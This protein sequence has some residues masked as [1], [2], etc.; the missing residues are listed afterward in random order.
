MI[1]PKMKARIDAMSQEELCRT[2]RFSPAGTPML[3]G[4]A[5]EYFQKRLAE[6]GGMTT[7]ISKKIG[8]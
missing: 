4:E 8:W 1:N 3:Q 7:A 2:W 5:G 6:L